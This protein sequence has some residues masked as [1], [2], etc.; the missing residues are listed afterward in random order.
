M[1]YFVGYSVLLLIIASL[2]YSTVLSSYYISQFP[3]QFLLVGGAT[4]LAIWR[5]KSVN[6]NNIYQFTNAFVL[7]TLLKLILYFVYLFVN[8]KYFPVEK[9][10]FTITFF[11]LYLLYSAYE[12]RQLVIYSKK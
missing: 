10:T 9:I 6:K 3:V 12:V 1:K 8:L 5:M 4:A 2:L 7:Q 11:I